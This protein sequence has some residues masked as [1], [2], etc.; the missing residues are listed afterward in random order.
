[1]EKLTIDFYKRTNVLQIARELMGK[2]LVTKWNGIF[3]SG[4][5][6]EV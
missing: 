2:I 5:I 1:M 3:T 4:R 6:V